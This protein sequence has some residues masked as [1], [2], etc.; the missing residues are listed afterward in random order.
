MR[1]YFGSKR[2]RLN[3][4]DTSLAVPNVSLIHDHP[5]DLQSWILAGELWNQRYIAVADGAA[6]HD[7]MTVH[8]GIDGS[9]DRATAKSTRLLPKPA[10]IYPPG[11][12]YRQVADEIHKT[13]YDNGTVTL[14]ER[15]GDTEHARVFWPHG[16]Q[17]VDAKPRV[18][19]LS[20]VARVAERALSQWQ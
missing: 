5:W 19:R 4:W 12:T 15:V 3:V 7:Y 13:S 16:E 14:N 2:W 11:E 20:E 10:E 9:W 1:T 17:W 18:A 8:T 6:T